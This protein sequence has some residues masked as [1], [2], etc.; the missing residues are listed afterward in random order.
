[1]GSLDGKVALVTGGGQGLGFGMAQAFADAGAKLVLTGRVKEKLEA[2]AD[3]LRG[4]GAEVATVAGD[5]QLRQSAKD[6]AATALE[7][8]GGI[9]VLVNNAQIIRVHLPI[10]EHDDE[11]IEV[12]IRSGLIGTIYM[13]QEA[14]PALKD[15]GGSVINIGSM[16]GTE[17]IVNSVAYAAAKEGVR[18]AT[19]VAAR[20]WGPD[21]IRVNVIAPG[22]TSE[23]F[24]AHFADNPDDLPQYEEQLSLGRFADP[25]KDIGGLAVFLAGDSCFLTG[26]T[27][28]CDGGQVMP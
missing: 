3:E 13:M 15:G 2:R 4:Q 16:N 25:V 11:T 17:G 10:V 18:G 27:L 9:D 14:Y 22:A 19:R 7:A 21:G 6:A 26:Q 1:M 23:R 28:F 5:I 8:F 24:L 20:E 12:S